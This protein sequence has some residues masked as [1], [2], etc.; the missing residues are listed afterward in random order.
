MPQSTVLC[1]RRKARFVGWSLAADGYLV[2]RWTETGRPPFNPTKRRC[3]G[4]SVMETMMRD[5]EGEMQFDWRADGG[6]PART[7]RRKDYLPREIPS[8]LSCAGA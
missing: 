3:L 2:L 5:R 7:S 6:P 8:G 4:T 1:P